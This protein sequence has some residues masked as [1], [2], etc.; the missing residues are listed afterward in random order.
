MNLLLGRRELLPQQLRFPT[1]ILAGPLELLLQFSDL[2]GNQP[3][4]SVM[5]FVSLHAIEQ[6]QLR[7]QRRVDG[8]GRPMID[9]THSL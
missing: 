8:V 2:S 9:S 5:T 3:V 1:S 4:S 7:G 6:T